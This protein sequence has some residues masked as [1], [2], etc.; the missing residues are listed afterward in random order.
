[1]DLA[2]NHPDAEQRRKHQS[3]VDL[4][5]PV[6]KGWCTEVG[7]ELSSV[8]VQ[9]HGGMG[10]MEE[11]GAAQHMR[12]ARIITIYEGTTGI[13]AADLTG[14]KLAMDGGK[15]MGELV[16]EM[17]Q[18]QQQLADSDD[19]ELNGLADA[20]GEGVKAL[21]S[22]TAQQLALLKEDP[23]A[24]LTEAVNYMMLSGYVYGGWQMAKAA[25]LAKDRLA[26]GDNSGFYQAKVIT[27][28]FYAEQIMPKAGALAQAIASRG[29][30]VMALAEEQF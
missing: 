1:M 15:A 29:S 18:E 12:D 5:I 30:T 26:A 21:Q 14:R 19:S 13:Q 10:F 2:R 16:V 25:R 22:A 9:V 6:V 8:G 27:A 23:N 24:A 11:T 4:L 17:E 20:L 28:R 7:Q 3:R